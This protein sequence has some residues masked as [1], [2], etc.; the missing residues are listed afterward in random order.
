MAEALAE[1]QGPSADAKTETRR[2]PKPRARAPKVEKSYDEDADV[3]G[4]G[5]TDVEEE[6]ATDVEGE[7]EGT[8]VEGED[9]SYDAT[10]GSTKSSNGEAGEKENEPRA[11]ASPIHA[12]ATSPESEE[13]NS[14]D[15]D[16]E[17]ED[18]IQSKKRN[19]QEDQVPDNDY[20]DFYS[21]EER[22]WNT[23]GLNLTRK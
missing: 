4:K 22:T 10:E 17:G 2:K 19:G 5:G 12:E 13:N 14:G 9:G 1:L 15:A 8:D 7:E 23:L 3:E 20:D 18:F 16:D 11:A 6:V 21:E